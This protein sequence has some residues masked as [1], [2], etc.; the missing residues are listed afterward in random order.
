MCVPFQVETTPEQKPTCCQRLVG[1]R[2]SRR[3]E[4]SALA[5]RRHWIKMVC[6]N[7]HQA[8]DVLTRSKCTVKQQIVIL[9]YFLCIF[10]A[11]KPLKDTIL[12]SIV[13]QIVVMCK[14]TLSCPPAI[15]RQPSL[16]YRFSSACCISV[17]RVKN[18]YGSKV[19]LNVKLVGKMFIPG[20][21]M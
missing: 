14:G 19:W 21:E 8:L 12:V 3:R 7:I 13:H 15:E 18:R 6:F 11:C 9:S 2:A 4:K 16:C 20:E 17:P 5:A 1:W 10:A